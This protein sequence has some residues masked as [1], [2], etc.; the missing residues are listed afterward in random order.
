MICNCTINF[1]EIIIYDK[2]FGPNL[3]FQKT[4]PKVPECIMVDYVQILLELREN[5]RDIHLTKKMIFYNHRTFLIRISDSLKFT[6]LELIQISGVGKFLK[7]T[8]KIIRIYI[9]TM[10]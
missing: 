8:N 10:D 4:V 5:Y 6:T 9:H 3:G 1:K 2:I 7:N